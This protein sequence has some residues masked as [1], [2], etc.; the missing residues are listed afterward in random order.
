ME[1]KLAEEYGVS[2]TPIR[3]ALLQLESEG[4]VKYEPNR[5]IIVLGISQQ[6][7]QDIYAI[8]RLIEGLAAFWAASRITPE[9]IEKIAETIDMIE[10]YTGKG[11]V[12]QV[13]NLDATLHYQILEASKSR[14]LKQALGCF[15]HHVQQART[16]SLKKPGRLEESLQEH[17]AIL[18]A[19][20]ERNPEQAQKAMNTHVANVNYTLPHEKNQPEN[21]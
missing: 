18:H 9:E 4:L 5:G 14:P 8:R 3:E 19:L 2:R 1:L 10:F 16:V 15:N 17:K 11:D 21:Y 7:I 12:E 6:D 13:T 20:K